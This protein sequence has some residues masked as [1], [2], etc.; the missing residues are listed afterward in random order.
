M[1][2]E[3]YRCWNCGIEKDKDARYYQVR[4]VTH[5][6]KLL[7]VPCCCEEC[8]EKVKNDNTELHKERYYT[9]KNQCIQVGIW[10]DK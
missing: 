8:A 7:F 9:T 2:D 6:G 1:N 10:K 4:I 3:G 5:D